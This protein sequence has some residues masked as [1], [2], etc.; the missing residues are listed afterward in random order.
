ME[1]NHLFFCAS[2]ASCGQYP[3][4]STSAS[5]APPRDPNEVIP[6]VPGDPTTS[7]KN[8]LFKL[9]TFT[10]PF[11]YTRLICFTGLDALLYIYMEK[12]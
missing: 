2:C 4:S 10:P 8:I 7:P 1:S 11:V 3:Q 9:L 6:S 5:S 12:R